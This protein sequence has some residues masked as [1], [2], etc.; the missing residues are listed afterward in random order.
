VTIRAASARSWHAR[1]Q[2]VTVP[3]SHDCEKEALTAVT[4]TSEV[5]CA[6][7]ARRARRTNRACVSVRPSIQ[8]H[9]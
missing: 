1:I 9:V 7:S 6:R 3:E 4:C 5:T 2:V 8:Q